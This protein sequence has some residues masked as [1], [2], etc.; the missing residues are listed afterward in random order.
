MLVLRRTTLKRKIRK[1]CQ[2][3]NIEKEGTWMRY[4]TECMFV[5]LNS[6]HVT[7]NLEVFVTQNGD[8]E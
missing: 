2:H 7:R 3:L 4:I 8:T 6:Q 5:L 1:R